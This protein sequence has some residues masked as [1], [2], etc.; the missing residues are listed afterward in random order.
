MYA[1]TNTNGINVVYN[2]NNQSAQAVVE[3]YNIMGQK[4]FTSNSIT[5]GETVTYK[6]VNTAQANVY[7]AHVISNG[8]TKTIKVVY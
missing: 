1:Y 3:I 5:G 8:K 7:I 4:L 2:N 6:P